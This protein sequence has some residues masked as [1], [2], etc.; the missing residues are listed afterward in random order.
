M[1]SM[2]YRQT[3][4]LNHVCGVAIASVLQQGEKDSQRHS[5]ANMSSEIEDCIRKKVD[6]VWQSLAFVLE[7]SQH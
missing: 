6:S 3:Y 4:V 5:M 7:H 2:Y 1:Y